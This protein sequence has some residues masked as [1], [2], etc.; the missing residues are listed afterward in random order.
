MPP[1]GGQGQR[2]LK[3]RALFRGIGQGALVSAFLLLTVVPL[4]DFLGR[5]L[6]GFHIPGSATY[7]QQL[8]FYLAF[9]GGLFAT[10]TGKHLDAFDRWFDPGRSDYG[11]A[12][13]F[14]QPVLQHRLRQC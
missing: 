14:S 5:P 9:L 12:R 13:S 7:T 8:T 4:V 10:W 2:R 1:A 6:A 3:A 11:G